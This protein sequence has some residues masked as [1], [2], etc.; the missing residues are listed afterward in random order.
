MRQINLVTQQYVQEQFEKTTE[1]LTT[2]EIVGFFPVTYYLG[3]IIAEWCRGYTLLGLFK[4][5]G[6]ISPGAYYAAAVYTGIT[7][8]VLKKVIH[9]LNRWLKNRN[10]QN[11]TVRQLSNH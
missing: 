8:L 4:V 9:P 3:H 5:E 10:I 2:A 7:F 6:E 11:N 1:L